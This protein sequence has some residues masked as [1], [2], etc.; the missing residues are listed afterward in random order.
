[1]DENKLKFVDAAQVPTGRVEKGKWQIIFE[2]IPAGKALVITQEEASDVA[3]RSS[4]YELQR[5]GQ[6]K[7][8]IARKV[9]DKDGKYKMYVINTNPPKLGKVNLNQ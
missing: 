2:K 8:L 4:L 6:F 7:N 1:M 5:K 9:N 3:V